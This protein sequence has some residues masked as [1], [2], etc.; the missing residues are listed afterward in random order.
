M[1]FVFSFILV[2]HGLLHLLG[3][4]KAFF[5]TDINRQVLGVSKPIGSIWLVT[6]I[7]FMVICIHFLTRKR[8]FYLAFI[9]VFVSQ[10]L[11]VLSWNESK[12][13]TITNI[14]ILL[15]GISAFASHR[16]NKTV[17]T[18][19]KDILQKIK[20]ASPKILSKNDI[21]HLPHSVQKWMTNSGVIGNPRVHSVRLKQKGTMRTKPSSRWMPFEAI[22][23]IN[24]LNP[25]FVWQTK[26]DAM[27]LLNIVG[28]DKL[29]NGKGKM[30]IKLA[31]VLP[32]V[33]ESDNPKINSAA[34]LRYLAEICWFPSAALNHYL[35][36]EAIDSKSAK[37][38]F[39]HKGHS[40]SGV[41]LF[42]EDS[43]FIAFEA[44]RYYLGNTDSQLKKWRITVEGYSVFNDIKIPYKSKVTWKLK[45]GDFNWLNL[46]V[47]ALE[48][49]S[50]MLY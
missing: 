11:I 12:Y 19:S 7:M 38:T 21:S 39:T 28:R 3:F 24:V 9:A 29:E 5:E 25:S 41:F 33:N 16:F 32:V 49:N 23:Y 40:V 37:A 48:Y 45:D 35:N 44:D 36:W 30:L 50:T 6:F 17:E 47:T 46:E 31:G 14:I 43:D 20:G 18:E 10:I 1:K 34:M 2:I 8:W 26:V 13:G 22:Q 4:V 27:P 42:N 15:V